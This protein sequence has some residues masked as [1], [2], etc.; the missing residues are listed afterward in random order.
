MSDEI[1]TPFAGF[2]WR[3]FA[4]FSFAAAA[5]FALLLLLEI[6]KGSGEQC[7]M[8]ERLDALPAAAVAPSA[9]TAGTGAGMSAGRAPSIPESADG[10]GG[11]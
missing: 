5:P 6:I 8:D 1:L 3:S 2:A 10:L 7:T 9:P 11:T 4:V